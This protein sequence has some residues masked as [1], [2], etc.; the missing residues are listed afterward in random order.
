MMTDDA[1][2][3]VAWVSRSAVLARDPDGPSPFSSPDPN[4]DYLLALAAEQGAALVTGDGH[5][6]GVAGDLPIHTPADF[7]A[8]ISRAVG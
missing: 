4:D 6:L 2:A 1:D 8:I 3:F 5:L 7:L